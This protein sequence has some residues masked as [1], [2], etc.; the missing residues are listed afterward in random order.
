M[1]L[2]VSLAALAAVLVACVSS[3]Q[4]AKPDSKP[5][6]NK[7]ADPTG[8]WIWSVPARNGGP[9][10]TNS[11]T[12]KMEGEKLT[13]K[14]TTP[15]RDGQVREATVDDG[16][17]TGSE[18]SFSITREFNGNSFTMKYSGK[19]EPDSI[20]GKVEFDRDGETQSRPWHATRQ[21]AKS[22]AAPKPDSSDKPD[23]K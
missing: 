12:L 5:A 19:V 16:K 13:G 2:K 23:M 20:T 6:D 17:V 18:I 1:S 7:P 9:D 4:D 15:G 22:E 21:A 3:A 8:T 10:R 11:L 14:L